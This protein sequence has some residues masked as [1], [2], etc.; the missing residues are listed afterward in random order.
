[1]PSNVVRLKSY[2]S[3]FADG[4]S[5]ITNNALPKRA[6]VFV[7]L[8]DEDLEITPTT[9]EMVDV[10]DMIIKTATVLRRLRKQYG[11]PTN[12]EEGRFRVDKAVNIAYEEINAQSK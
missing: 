7:F 10:E 11:R 6:L 12:H 9:A 3:M 8:G 1:M 2:K 4:K 5:S